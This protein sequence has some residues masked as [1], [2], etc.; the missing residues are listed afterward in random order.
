MLGEIRGGVVLLLLLVSL[1]LAQNSP[2][3]PVFSWDCAA[4]PGQVCLEPRGLLQL[5]LS[6]TDPASWGERV[7]FGIKLE[8]TTSLEALEFKAVPAL[9]VDNT[10][11]ADLLQAYAAS[12]WGDIRLS[13][14]K[15]LKYGGPWDDTLLGRNGHWG[16][17]AHYTPTA[18]DWASVEA[19]YLPDPG[20]AGGQGFVGAQAGPF[21][22][23]TFAQVIQGGLQWNP[24]VG[25]E[26]GQNEVYWQ[27]DR[28]FWAN[29]HTPLP[30]G[31]IVA[32]SLECPP[33]S[34]ASCWGR[35]LPEQ[36]D[37]SVQALLR[38]LDEGELGLLIWWNPDWSLLGQNDPNTGLP[39]S[40]LDW[41]G[42][43]K[44][45]YLSLST[46]L[47]QVRLGLDASLAPVGAYRVYLEFHTP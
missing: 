32:Y 4:L 36:S 45:F 26:W 1:G 37:P 6:R 35:G 12:A 41:L 44:K 25:L 14:G 43:P 11:Q 31:Q 19:A 3:S 39:L 9:W 16:V 5:G 42:Q 2:Q 8:A 10:L 13:L 18:L 34:E 46:T 47:R 30:L 38:L 7:A 24:R 22:L 29:L 27:S 23:G 20:L 21:R 15:R 17:F 33:T 40:F 28:G